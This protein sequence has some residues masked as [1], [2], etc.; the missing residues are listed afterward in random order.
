MKKE[1]KRETYMFKLRVRLGEE[2]RKRDLLVS[3]HL[4]EVAK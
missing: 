4:R 2:N 3:K 1:A